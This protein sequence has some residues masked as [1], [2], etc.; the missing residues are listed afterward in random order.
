[1]DEPQPNVMEFV[2]NCTL[3]E[4]YHM[5]NSRLSKA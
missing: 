4:I 2:L 1:M 3:K 5:G